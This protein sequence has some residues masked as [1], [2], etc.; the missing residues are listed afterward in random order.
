MTHTLPE[1]PFAPDSLSPSISAETFEFHHGK[2]HKTYVDNLNKLI[3]GTEFADASLEDI[4][5]KASGGVFNNAAQH[6][7][8]SFYWNCL[9]PGGGAPS[10]E[11][12]EA[13]TRSFGCAL[14]FIYTAPV[15]ADP[16]PASRS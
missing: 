6:F 2:H 16:V 1:L 15:F 10:G 7:N 4:V 5:R 9:K 13:L 14:P 8:H 3:A 11:L 12:E